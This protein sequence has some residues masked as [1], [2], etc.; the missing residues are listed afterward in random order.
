MTKECDNF[1]TTTLEW[2]INLSDH[3][4][5]IKEK[6]EDVNSRQALSLQLNKNMTTIESTRNVYW[7]VKEN[8]HLAKFESL[9][10]LSKLHGVHM[11]A[12][13]VHGNSNTSRTMAEFFLMLYLNKL[14]WTSRGNKKGICNVFQ[15]ND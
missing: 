3:T 2:H 9:Q 5:A 8:L 1:P 13:N 7:I 11:K 14:R 4:N 10:K 12:F 6:Y 15:S